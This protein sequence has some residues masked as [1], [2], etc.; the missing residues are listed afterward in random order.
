MAF[1]TDCLWLRCALGPQD[2]V[3]LDRIAGDAGRPGGRIGWTEPDAAAALAPITRLIDRKALP[4]ARLVRVVWFSKDSQSNWGVPWHQDRIIAVAERHDVPGFGNWS[5]KSGLWHC[6]PPQAILDAMLFVRVHLDDCDA[7]NGAMEI[8]R[9]SHAA[10][11]VPMA[12]AAKVAETYP[13]ECCSA[14]RGDV[15]I[16]PM[17]VLHRSLPAQVDAPRRAL[18]LDFAA[19]PL[20]MPLQWLAP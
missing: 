8:A 17:L 4:G 15:Q 5:C 12:E 20:P 6:E 1:S 11:S 2:L 18:R 10:G 9:G 3:A 19:A 13:T 16:L 14:Q 7:S